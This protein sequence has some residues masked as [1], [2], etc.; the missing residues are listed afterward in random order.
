MDFGCPII[1]KY[2]PA[3]I[4][5]TALPEYSFD[6]ESPEDI[7]LKIQNIIYSQSNINFLI[8]HGLKRINKLSWGETSQ[9]ILKVYEKVLS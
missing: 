7:V 5:A 6:P 1:N 9:N 2:N 4:E 8:S 3:I